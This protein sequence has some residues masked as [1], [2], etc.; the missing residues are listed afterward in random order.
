MA[1]PL[2]ADPRKLSLELKGSQSSNLVDVIVQFDPS[3]AISKVLKT[4]GETRKEYKHFNGLVLRLPAN[5]LPA[6]AAI[7]GV[8]YVSV[9]RKLERKLEFAEAGVLANIAHQYG[10]NGSGVGVA[11]IDSGV[12]QHPDLMNGSVSRVVYSENFVTGASNAQDAYG[13]GTHVAGI[14]AGDATA[15]SGTGSTR[16]FGGIAPRANIINLRVL[17]QNG[18]GDDLSVI[19]AI[20]RAIELKNQYNIRVMNLSLGRPIR[21]SYTLDPL[22]QAV[23]HAWNAG[24][25]VCANRRHP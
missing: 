9:N 5:A 12:T 22:C 7:P 4:R 25:V 11:V 19:A 10:Y 2:S 8:K 1:L 20:D 17:D 18:S 3:A 16:K 24:I 21:E 15:S 23:E 14:I 13:H 6:I